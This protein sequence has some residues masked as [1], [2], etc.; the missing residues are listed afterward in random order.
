M[1]LE[2]REVRETPAGYD[3]TG[4]LRDVN[5]VLALESGAG[6][7]VFAD[8]LAGLGLDGDVFTNDRNSTDY[9]AGQVEAAVGVLELLT[10]AN[11]VLAGRVLAEVFNKME[12]NVG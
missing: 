3:R 1:Y 5:E 8:I 7:R 9:R 12:V 2:G 10:K 11:D 4:D 6:I